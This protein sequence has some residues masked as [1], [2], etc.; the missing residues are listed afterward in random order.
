MYLFQLINSNNLY[1]SCQINLINE[2]TRES[3]LEENQ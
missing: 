3:F 2:K 1:Y